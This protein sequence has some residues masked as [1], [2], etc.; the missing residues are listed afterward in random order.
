MKR[1]SWANSIF[2]TA[3][4]LVCLALILLGAYC[5]ADEL[6]IYQ[7]AAGRSFLSFRQASERNAQAAKKISKGQIGWIYIDGTSVDHPLMQGRDNSEYLNKDPYGDFSCAGSIF[8]DSACSPDLTDAY[9]V[10]YGHHMSAG[11]MFGSLDRY[12][13]ESYLQEHAF[14][15]VAAGGRIYRL[16]LFAV[17]ECMAGEPCIF[18]PGSRSLQEVESYIAGRPDIIAS[19]SAQGRQ[20]LALTTCTAG[21]DLRR[22]VVCGYISPLEEE[23][24]EI[25]DIA[26]SLD[27]CRDG[28]VRGRAGRGGGYTR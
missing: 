13:E 1:K 27:A 20:I 25:T 21:G 4:G 12:R 11:R 16:E 3:V 26:Y 2:D 10:I 17:F 19:R 28:G 5:F 7:G 23:H 9:S 6:Y 18:S 22:L 15:C 14:G 8:L 24:E